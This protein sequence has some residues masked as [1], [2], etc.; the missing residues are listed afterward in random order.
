MHTGPRL[1]ADVAKVISALAA[2]TISKRNVP[3][4]V[5]MSLPHVV[6]SF[7]K[8]DGTTAGIALLVALFFGRV[9]EQLVGFGNFTNMA[10]NTVD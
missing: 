7:S 4:L 2:M 8:F 1:A 3:L 10:C 6:T 9:L 5:V